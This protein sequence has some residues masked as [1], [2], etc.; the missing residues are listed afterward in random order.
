MESVSL[1]AHRCPTMSTWSWIINTIITSRVI[2]VATTGGAILPAR[3]R[4]RMRRTTTAT[5]RRR[6]PHVP[7][8]VLVLL[9]L[10][11]VVPSRLRSM[12]RLTDWG[13]DCF[14]IRSC[15]LVVRYYVHTIF[16]S[17]SSLVF[18]MAWLVVL[19]IYI[20]LAYLVL[21]SAETIIIRQACVLWRM[22]WKYYY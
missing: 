15:W 20:Y 14:N 4:T 11:P 12:R 16:F 19:S 1:R 7:R 21:S 6:R 22:R 8:R 9:L 5:Q 2:G 10:M 13:W 3:S 18:L 17:S